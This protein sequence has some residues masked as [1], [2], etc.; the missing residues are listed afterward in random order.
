M[1]ANVVKLRSPLTIEGRT[2]AELT[3]RE[4]TVTELIAIERSTAGKNDIEKDAAFF[5]IS[6]GVSPDTI[7][8]LKQRDWNELRA[9]YFDVLGNDEQTPTI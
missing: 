9:R 4:L 7:G 3:I 6:C 8:A 5:A 2:I 1:D